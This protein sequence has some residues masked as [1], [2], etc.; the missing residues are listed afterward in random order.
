MLNFPRLKRALR[1]K[2]RALNLV[3]GLRCERIR[4]RGSHPVVSMSLADSCAT[5]TGLVVALLCELD[6]WVRD[7][8]D[9]EKT[10]LADTVKIANCILERF[11]QRLGI[12]VICK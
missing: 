9:S 5:K 7:L 12:L 1:R 2:L 6:Y 8:K 10:K 3:G 4:R 11:S